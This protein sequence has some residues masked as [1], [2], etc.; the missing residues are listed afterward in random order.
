MR[1]KYPFPQMDVHLDINIGLS[2]SFA[3]ELVFSGAIR[4]TIDLLETF[5]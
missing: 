4:C 2:G 1:V 3:V 5:Y